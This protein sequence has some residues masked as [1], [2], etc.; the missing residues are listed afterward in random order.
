MLN[1]IERMTI[2]LPTD[3]AALVKGAVKGGNY[4]SSSEV[5][6]DALRAWK[7]QHQAAT[8]RADTQGKKLKAKRSKTV[9]P[10]LQALARMRK[11]LRNRVDKKRSLV[12]ELIADR[13]REALN[14]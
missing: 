11:L 12:D 5:I 14:E 9:S 13:R 6:R 8:P 2:T 10:Q 3:M 1:A 4:A 7:A